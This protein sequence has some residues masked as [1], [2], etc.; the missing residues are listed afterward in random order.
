[1]LF[2]YEDNILWDGNICTKKLTF[3]GQ[4]KIIG[5]CVKR[6]LLI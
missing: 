1:M 2:P 5:K 4:G 6:F 3:K